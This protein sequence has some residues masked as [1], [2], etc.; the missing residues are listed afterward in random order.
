MF[1]VPDFI[2]AV[3]DTCIYRKLIFIINFLI[4]LISKQPTHSY[5]LFDITFAERVHLRWSALLS[6]TTHYSLRMK[7]VRQY[8]HNNVVHVHWGELQREDLLVVTIFLCCHFS[9]CWWFSLWMQLGKI[10]HTGHLQ[11]NS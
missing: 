1:S 5:L 6:N 9:E 2:F 7:R 4:Q 11:C 3:V 8:N 10:C